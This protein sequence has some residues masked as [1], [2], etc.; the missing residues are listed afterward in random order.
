[1]EPSQPGGLLNVPITES[2]RAQ[3]AQDRDRDDSS[4][5]LLPEHRQPSPEPQ[6][7]SHTPQFRPPPSA[8]QPPFPNRFPSIHAPAVVRQQRPS[9]PP[10][11][12]TRQYAPVSPVPEEDE[13]DSIKLR[14]HTAIADDYDDDR[15]L[16][17]SSPGPVPPLWTPIWLRKW[18]LGLFAFIFAG[19]LLALILLWHF[20]GQDDGFHVNPNM[21]HYA[22]AYT[23]TIIVVFV[24]AAWRMV[25]YHSK[26]AM[27]YDALQNGP[28][29]PC[30]SL[31]VDYI[32]KHQL[33]ALFE[34]FKNSDFAVVTTSTGFVLLKVVTV[35]STGLLLARPTQVT[36]KGASVQAKGFSASSLNS[37]SALGSSNTLAQP[38]YAYYGTMA[39]GMPSE[40]GVTLEMAYSAI[41]VKS[42]TP[43]GENY[44]ISGLVD[45]F[46]PT[47]SCQ[48]L[49]VQ[50][51]SPR[52]VND[53]NSANALATSSNITFIIP[54]GDVCTGKSLV[55]VPADNPYTEILPKRQVIG[56]MQQIFCGTENASVP[57][58]AGPQG[59]LFTITD[60]AYQQT[61][62]DNATDLAGGTFTIASDVSRTLTNITNVVCNPSYMITKAQVTNN[63]QLRG[64]NKA[65]SIDLKDGGGNNTLQ[66]FSDW[67]ATNVLSQASI[68]AQV[69]FGD[70]VNDDTI[71]DSSA[72]FKLMALTRG[73]QSIDTLMD[74]NSMIDAA[75]DI[76]QGIL[77]QYA[78]Q[79]LRAADNSDVEGGKVSRQELRL[80]V[81]DVS[82]WTMASASG[83]L[84]LFCIAL[85]F[86]APRAV[87]PRDPS[88]IAAVATTLARSTELN[89]LLRKQGVPNSANQKIGLAGYEFGTAIASTDSGRTSFKIVTSEGEFNEPLT[90]PT[91]GMKWWTPFT[92][93]VPWLV[94]T[95]T[96]PL[97]I[98]IALELIQ[99]H[100]DDHSGFYTV[101]DDE[102][103]EVYSHYIPGL[104]MLIL[105]ALVNML[106]FNV[107]LF[108][109]WNN[110]ASSGA[111]HRKSILNN[112][113]GRSPPSAFLQALRTGSFGAML[114]IAAATAA[115]I[116]TVIASGLYY[117]NH[118]SVEGAS[119]SITQTDA[120]SL[121]WADSFSNDNGAGALM[122]LIMH[123]S[124][125][126][127]Q[128][129]FE[130]LVF[131]KLSLN[132]SALTTNTLT[133]V[134]GSGGYLLPGVRANLKCDVIPSDSFS[135]STEAAGTDSAYT[136]DQAFVTVRAN[137]PD[138][139]HLGGQHGTDDFVLYENNFELPSGGKGTYAGA[140]LDLLFGENA[141]TYGNYGANR[142]QYIGDNPPVGCPS[143]AFTF[144]HFRLNSVDKTPVTTMVCYQHI[145][146]LNAIVTLKPNSTTIDSSTPPFVQESSVFQH[147]NAAASSSSIKTFDF[148]IQNN[149]AQEMTVFNGG[150]DTPA[151]NPSS[152]STFDI[153]FQ[154]IINGTEPHSPASLAGPHNQ[155]VLIRAI[156]RFY[157]IYM[158]QAISANMRGPVTSD[159]GSS[160]R[161]LRRQSSSL[162]TTS[163][164]AIDT[165]RLVQD[166]DSKIFLQVLLSLM[167]ALS[168]AAWSVT[169]FQRVLPCNPCSIAGTM[170]LLAGSDL[171]HSTD[172]GLCECCGKPRRR[173]FGFE[174]D[175]PES[176]HA[177]PDETGGTHG[178]EVD[179]REQIIDDG[180]EWFSTD[181]FEMVFAGKTY[182]MGWWRER[183]AIG[184]RRRY[185]V[186]VG[187]RADGS[188]DQDWE[189]GGRR[190]EGE[191]FSGFMI[192]SSRGDRD[193]RGGYT[194]A[195]GRNL[196]I[197]GTSPDPGADG[198]VIMMPREP[199]PGVYVPET[200]RTGARF[201]PSRIGGGGGDPGPATMARRPCPVHGPGQHG[202]VHGEA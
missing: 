150:S 46:V 142:G 184:K 61:L 175:R 179:D 16:P 99:K 5:R 85:I 58:S 163:P 145:E 42:D 187:A 23:P 188:D 170:S 22:W 202:P 194:R 32:S 59:L 111:V 26:L 72:I 79:T 33:V 112:I 78:H 27:P 20:D 138:S 167:I 44:T 134:S 43:V 120:F 24:V 162:T 84:F 50:L 181:H 30:E 41:T 161:L 74:P 157:Q 189:L 195:R 132:N 6:D 171:V 49:D 160:S 178:D 89:R 165:P 69:L 172:D 54:A 173:S 180:A 47:M 53:A 28:V 191:G 152:A 57:D 87:V 185:G 129:T 105:A 174:T 123:Q 8:L 2:E 199:S 115:S 107:A 7:D 190:P 62:F 36:Q 13:P 106:D 127:P 1:M 109:P 25:D 141:T 143:L 196:S 113:L 125:S 183:R 77:S 102:W 34:A 86:I 198:R 38:V 15:L 148:R 176:I 51:N 133:T 186:D 97:A 169:K 104:I 56:T 75:T 193:G 114:S 96:L 182:S 91:T 130:D 126:Y 131:P 94:L 73:S 19:F 65:V 63:T 81:N 90:Q 55:S 154:A 64:S 11:F 31:L 197:S 200:G 116:L 153:F 135:I 60:V 18:V 136:T 117:V 158:A 40:N 14:P 110:L 168:A 67:N 177:G 82:V 98:I 35:F 156:T 159:T 48:T 12:D 3:A 128:F 88:S 201:E 166:K 17:V 121:R 70:T 80:R 71:S 21:S 101:A 9:Y 83:L 140:Q 68:A 76:H 52:V 147:E 37:N 119:V 10:R 103:T 146:G 149:L 124:F 139:C 164:T 100:S 155:N 108:T 95:L 29:M 66:G 45:A 118:F 144:G 93:S 137:L 39:Q 151:T 4:D 92:A 192:P 122:N